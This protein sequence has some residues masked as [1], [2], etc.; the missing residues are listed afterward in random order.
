MHYERQPR[1]DLVLGPATCELHGGLGGAW[2]RRFVQHHR[3]DQRALEISL[4]YAAR[5]YL[6]EPH[7]SIVSLSRCP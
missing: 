6:S 5:Q 7:T 1:G 4:V 3:L 2:S